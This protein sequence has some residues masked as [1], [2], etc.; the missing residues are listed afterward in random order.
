M[1]AYS[2]Y[3]IFSWECGIFLKVVGYDAQHLQYA[4][5][6]RR[7]LVFL[8]HLR[9]PQEILFFGRLNSHLE[10][11]HQYLL[12]NRHHSRVIRTLTEIN[13][14]AWPPTSPNQPI[15]SDRICIQRPWRLRKHPLHSPLKHGMADRK[16]GKEPTPKHVDTS[17]PKS[18]ERVI[19]EYVDRKKS[20]NFF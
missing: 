3:A 4:S 17:P 13:W 7:L 6:I 11:P 8:V 12:A 2:Y 20:Y 9:G 15:L 14:G 10:D 16:R 19:S 5:C 18:V 1:L